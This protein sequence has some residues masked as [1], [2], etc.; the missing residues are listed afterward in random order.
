M[1]TDL[2]LDTLEQTLWSQKAKEITTSLG[3]IGD[4]YDNAMAETVNRLKNPAL[5]AGLK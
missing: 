4:V 2:T 3:N 1:T 5:V